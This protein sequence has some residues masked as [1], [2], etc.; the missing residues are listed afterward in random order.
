MPNFKCTSGHFFRISAVMMMDTCSPTLYK[1]FETWL[2]WRNDLSLLF[3]LSQVIPHR[4]LFCSLDRHG[5]FFND[6]NHG[7]LGGSS[8]H[9]CLWQCLRHCWRGLL[10]RLCYW[11]ELTWNH[12]DIAFSVG[13]IQFE[14]LSVLRN[15]NSFWYK[16]HSRW[17]YT[18]FLTSRSFKATKRVFY[19]TL[20][21]VKYTKGHQ[22]NVYTH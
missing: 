22:G 21:N 6:A 20:K 10:P 2:E 17:N 13:C 16:W 15:I 12:S 1:P 4:I 7:I 9:L 14:K 18:W 5:G 11:Y 19:W 3:A 8:S